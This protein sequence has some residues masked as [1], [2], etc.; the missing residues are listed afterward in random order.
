M[1]DLAP[2][3]YRIVVNYV[4]CEPHQTQEILGVEI[5]DGVVRG[6]DMYFAKARI[7]VQVADHD[8]HGRGSVSYFKW[9]DQRRD[10]THVTGDGL[11]NG[12]ATRALAPGMYKIVVNYVES[13]PDQRQEVIGAELGDGTVRAYD[14]YFAKGEMNITALDNDGWAGGSV[15]YYRWSDTQRDYSHVTGD[16]LNNGKATRELAPGLYKAVVNYVESKPDQRRELVG[17][18]VTDRGVSAVE[19]YF[20]KG[21]IETTATDN[22]G[23]ARGSVSYYRWSDER[24]DYVHVTGDGLNNGRASRELAPGV[25]KLVVNYVESEPDQRREVT[26]VVIEDG[27]SRGHLFEFGGPGSSPPVISVHG[28]LERGNGDGLLQQG[29][30]AE[31]VISLSDAD[32][33]SAALVCN[34]LEL[35]IA[36]T[37][38][39]R[40]AVPLSIKG[41]YECRIR[42]RDAATPPN[43]NSWTHRFSTGTRV[44]G[45]T[46]LVSSSVSLSD[47][48]NGSRSSAQ[49]APTG[50]TTGTGADGG[51]SVRRTVV[52]GLID[53]ALVQSGQDPTTERA[54]AARELGKTTLNPFATG[55][56]L[57]QAIDRVVRS[58]TQP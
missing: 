16:G 13:E 15:S 50:G 54:A 28:P 19:Y 17:F 49:A 34:Q 14:F 4:T 11:N 38:L 52:D 32:L 2:G 18:E 9:S 3:Q 57:D 1:R 36:S 6:Y 31:F 58:V 24:R 21:R 44:G 53:A 10:Y 33:L 47:A 23:W 39:H 27:M 22:S 5:G 41:G 51:G 12:R 46:R 30:S 45:A 29:E 25:Y 37:G 48:G 7:E 40:L 26:N 42:A 56:Q 20:A 43:I 55:D 8:G 35:P